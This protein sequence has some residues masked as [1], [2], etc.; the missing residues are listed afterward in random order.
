MPFA[1]VHPPRKMREKRGRKTICSAGCF[2]SSRR[3]RTA[4]RSKKAARSARCGTAQPASTF[5][6]RAWKRRF[7][8]SSAG[9]TPSSDARSAR[10]TPCCRTTRRSILRLPRRGS[11]A[12]SFAPAKHFHSGVLSGR[13]A[14]HAATAQVSSSPT[15]RPA[16]PSAAGCASSATLSTGWCSI[17]R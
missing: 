3:S 4:F 6:K 14:P 10:S 15:R 13:Q 11:T 7:P 2:A 9:T 1:A 8:H 17:H 12:F 16:R 5:P